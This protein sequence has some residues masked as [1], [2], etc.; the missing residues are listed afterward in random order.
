MYR[1]ADIHKEAEGH[2]FVNWEPVKLL[3]DFTD[4]VRFFQFF[5]C[6]YRQHNCVQLV[7]FIWCQAYF[8]DGFETNEPTL[9]RIAE[10]AGLNV[11]DVQTA[12]KDDKRKQAV[13]QMASD[14][15]RKGVSGIE[16]K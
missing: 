16:L 13:K 15:S 5:F 7:L 11:S 2:V 6:R 8:T 3:T 4:V 12:L 14:Y 9:L 1:L 10:E